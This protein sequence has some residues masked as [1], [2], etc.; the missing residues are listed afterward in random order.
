MRVRVFDF[1]KDYPAIV[2][3]WQTHG[4]PPVP[5]AMLPVH[6]LMVEVDGLPL[7]AGFVYRTDSL[8]GWMEFLVSNPD[9]GIKIRSVA[10]DT[11]IDGLTRVAKEL[12]IQHMIT[13]T[14]RS[15]LVRRLEKNGFQVGDTQTTQ[16]IWSNHASS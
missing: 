3:W 16:L 11:L 6:G 1:Q 9:A 8:M 15:G 4:F 7:A 5:E 13:T 12:G 2:G 14:N 10:L